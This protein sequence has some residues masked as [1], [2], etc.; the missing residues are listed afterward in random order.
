[1]ASSSTGFYRLIES[2]V[3]ISFSPNKVMS[4]MRRSLFLRCNSWSSREEDTLRLLTFLGDDVEREFDDCHFSDFL[5]CPL[6]YVLLYTMNNRFYSTSFSF[7][8]LAFSS[9]LQLPLA[10]VVYFFYRRCYHLPLVSQPSSSSSFISD[11]I[12]QAL[13]HSRSVC[14]AFALI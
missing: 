4:F 2:K 12:I 10:A 5:L 3:K 8:R 11:T 6:S 1:M 7:W 14:P 13:G 9:R